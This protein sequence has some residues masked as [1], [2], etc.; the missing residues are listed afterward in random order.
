MSLDN[1]EKINFVKLSALS[2][3]GQFEINRA[4]TNI[5][6]VVNDVVTINTRQ[7]YVVPKGE[8]AF[9]KKGRWISSDDGDICVCFQ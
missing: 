9:S 6:E 2:P 5:W 8:S 7:V 1:E 3:I 4:G